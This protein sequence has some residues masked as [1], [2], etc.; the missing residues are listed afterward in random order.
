MLLFG[1]IYNDIRKLFFYQMLILKNQTNH[2]WQGVIYLMLDY[3][4]DRGVPY[5][6]T[7]EVRVP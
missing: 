4:E 2:A 7:V 1:K 5:A 3:L 6:Q